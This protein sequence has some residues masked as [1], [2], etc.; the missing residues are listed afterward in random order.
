M[1]EDFEIALKD[2]HEKFDS[3]L[4]TEDMR[5]GAD[6]RMR[7]ATSFPLEDDDG[8]IISEDRRKLTDRRTSDQDIDDITDY[9]NE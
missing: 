7:V 9:L 8:N 2:V 3:L 6:R 1:D 4:T 5:S